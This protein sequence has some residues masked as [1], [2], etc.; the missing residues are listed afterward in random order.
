MAWS[1]WSLDRIVILFVGLAYL[2]IWIQVTM[3]HY[4][5]NFHNKAMWAPVILSPLICIASVLSTLINSNGWFTLAL[6]CFWVGALAGLIGF[7]FHFRGV[8]LRVGGY[9][10]R[11]FLMGPPVIMPL[12]YSAMSILGL[13][14]VYGA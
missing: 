13:I 12:L 3:S 6:I 9:A 10:L 2:F 8:G 1:N 11:N 14:A 4:R 5:Q 7:F